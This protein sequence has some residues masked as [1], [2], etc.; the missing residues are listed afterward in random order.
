[1]FRRRRGA[2]FDGTA[3]RPRS[4]NG[5]SSTHLRWRLPAGSWA[6]AEVTLEVVEP[7]TQPHL[8]FWALQASFADGGRRHGGAHLGL[9]WFHAHPGSTAVNW[10]GYGADG[11]ELDGSVSSLPSAPGN[12]NTR[13][14]AWR[15]ATPYQL[16][17]ERADTGGW[18]GSVTDLTSN[19]RTDVRDLWAPGAELTDVMMWSEVFAP[20]DGE[21]T[22]VRWSAPVVETADGTRTAIDA[23]ITS[24]QS[25]AEGGCVTSNSSLVRL[26]SVDGDDR[27]QGRSAVEQ[28]TATV[29]HTPPGATMDLR[30]VPAGPR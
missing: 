16:R 13:D 11:R 10:G 7:P 22:A 23:V 26:S 19:E 2:R 18:R 8:Y 25:V 24:Y 12:A 5:A 1:V 21:P 27:S 14:F 17:I 9:Q 4:S 15:S 28:R 20:C 6:A 30:D 29:R 3:G